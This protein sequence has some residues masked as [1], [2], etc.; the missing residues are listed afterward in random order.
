MRRADTASVRQTLGDGPSAKYS[1]V[2]TVAAHTRPCLQ[3][4]GP[5]QA[6]PGHRQGKLPQ[7]PR[8]RRLQWR[9][10]QQAARPERRE[11]QGRH[12]PQVRPLAASRTR[13]R[14]A[15]PQRPRPQTRHCS[16]PPA[17]AGTPPFPGP[18]LLGLGPAGEPR[19]RPKQGLR[20]MTA[21]G[22]EAPATLAVK[23]PAPHRLWRPRMMLIGGGGGPPWRPPRLPRRRGRCPR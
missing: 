13:H 10:P 20:R 5:R 11:P 4:A 14:Q 12:G 8:G 9:E 2:S 1:M 6:R 19:P 18:G 7:W 22:Q 23:R 16:G 21:P 15:Q 17:Y 3:W